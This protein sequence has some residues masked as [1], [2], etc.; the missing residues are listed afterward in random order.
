VRGIPRPSIDPARAQAED[1]ESPN[2]HRDD[3]K[4]EPFRT[5]KESKG[6]PLVINE[7][8]MKNWGRDREAHPGGKK[9]LGQRFGQLIQPKDKTGQ[10]EEG[11]AIQGRRFFFSSSD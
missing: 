9:G 10:R 5:L 6:N 2:A 1:N 7:G 11:D 4:K 8:E 3:R